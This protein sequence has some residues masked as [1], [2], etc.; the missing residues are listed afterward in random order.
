MFANGV[1][2][3]GSMLFM[4]SSVTCEK[5]SLNLLAISVGSVNTVK[6]A[7]SLMVENFRSGFII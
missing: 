6:Y 5:Y 4:S 3:A 7:A 2:V 1:L